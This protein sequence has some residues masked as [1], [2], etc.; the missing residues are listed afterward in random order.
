M[1]LIGPNSGTE[2]GRAVEEARRLKGG[3]APR[4]KSG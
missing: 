3:P 4:R 2:R 1:N